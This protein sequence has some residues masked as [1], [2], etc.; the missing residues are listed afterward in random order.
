MGAK[1]GVDWNLSVY[2]VRS[3]WVLLRKIENA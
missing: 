2:F 3:D 1:G